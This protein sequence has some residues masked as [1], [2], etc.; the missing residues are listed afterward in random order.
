MPIPDPTRRLVVYSLERVRGRIDDYVIRALSDLRPHARTLIVS[1]PAGLGSS[2]RKILLE[3]ADALSETAAEC[4]D[5]VDYR[6]VLSRRDDLDE[7]DEIVL[8]GDAWFGMVHDITPVLQRMADVAADAMTMVGADHGPPPGFPGQ[9]FPAPV[10]PFT[11]TSLTPAVA[12][13]DAWEQFWAE[14]V[15]GGA[16]E[17][18]WRLL[19]YLARYGFATSSAFDPARYPTGEPAVFSARRLLADGCPL[20]SRLPFRLFPPFLHQHGVIGRQLLDDIA[21]TGFP[22]PYV[23]Q[24]LVR[25]VPPRAVNTNAGLLDVIPA[26]TPVDEGILQT[27]P[28]I[29]VIVHVSDFDGIAHVLDHVS[30]IPVPYDLVLTTTDGM[31]ASR[32]QQILDDRADSLLR[33]AEIRVVPDDP[34]RDMSDLLVG[35]RDLLLGDRYELVVKVHARAARDKTVNRLR[36]FRRYQ[37]ENLLADR[38]HVARVIAL[39]RAEPG[40][41]IVFPPMMHIGYSIAGRG[42]AGLERVAARLR[43]ELGAHV[44]PDLMSPLAPFGGMWIARPAALRR[45]SERPWRYGDYRSRRRS[46][47]LAHVQERLLVEAAAEDGFHVRTVLTPEHASIS[48]TAVEFKLDEMGR[49]VRGYPLDQIQFLHT[50]GFVGNGSPVTLLRMYLRLNHPR[51]ARA[52]LPLYRFAVLGRSAARFLREGAQRASR[53]ARSQRGASS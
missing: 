27:P 32:L 36:Y 43:G 52:F 13:S 24:S 49:A 16:R 18:E 37:L 14:D 8:T 51:L 33:T 15:P 31:R 11:W 46:R 2:S 4:F 10:V 21:Q 26:A 5:P 53:F 7:F 39:F 50:A 29:V 6:D 30:Q 48:H 40:L 25:S 9:G 1:A 20:V 35:C 19:P 44:P 12:R 45:M 22:V 34:G 23:L 28:E 42:W 47:E 41:G 38:G 3:H 17:R